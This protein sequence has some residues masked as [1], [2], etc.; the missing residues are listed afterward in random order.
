MPDHWHALIAISSPLTVSR[1]LQ[2]IKKSATR[3]LHKLRGTEGP[4]WQHQ[5]WDRFVRNAQ[6]FHERLGY[7]HTNPVR[8]GFVAQPGDWRWSSYNNFSPDQAIVQHCPIEIDFM[9]LP[10]DYRA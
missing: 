10:S 6:E 2:D 8:K 1:V 4:L 3:K 5:F 9:Q 7:M